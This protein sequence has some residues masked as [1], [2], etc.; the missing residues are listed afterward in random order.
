M[1]LNQEGG[2]TIH[3]IASIFKRKINITLPL[4][5]LVERTEW[6]GGNRATN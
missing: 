4:L 6:G 3:M 5:T 1:A 2:K